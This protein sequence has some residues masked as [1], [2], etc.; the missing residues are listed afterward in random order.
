MIL[1][2]DAA[3]LR[4]HRDGCRLVVVQGAAEGIG[5]RVH[6]KVNHPGDDIRRWRAGG[7]DADEAV[8]FNFVEIAGSTFDTETVGRTIVVAVVRH[9]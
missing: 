8:T 6:V 9:P 4:P 3:H 7:E 2:D 1:E 5:S